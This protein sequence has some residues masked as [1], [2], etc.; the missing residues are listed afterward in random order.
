MSKK[1]PLGLMPEW[2]HK[3]LR[4]QEIREAVQRY[5]DKGK[6]V[7]INWI[8]EEYDLQG[9]FKNREEI[10]EEEPKKE[11]KDEFEGESMVETICKDYG[12]FTKDQLLQAEERAFNAARE[13]KKNGDFE[14]E[15]HPVFENVRHWDSRKYPTLQDYLNSKGEQP[16][17][18]FYAKGYRPEQ[19]FKGTQWAQQPKETVEELVSEVF[20]KKSL[21][22]LFKEEVKKDWVSG[23]DTLRP[24]HIKEPLF[25]WDDN[26]VM[27]FAIEWLNKRVQFAIM[28][29]YAAVPVPI[30]IEIEMFKSKIKSGGI[31]P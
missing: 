7:P 4:L 24:P 25:V 12:L 23:I 8:A 11:I 2:R 1:P 28:H 20:E 9:W 15:Q 21:S 14:W 17:E 26:K 22:P 5:L 30:Q 18:H 19:Y 3:E 16:Y 6:A 27:K 10:K 29:D 31:A 13:S